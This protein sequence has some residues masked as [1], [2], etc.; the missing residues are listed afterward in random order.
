MYPF[1]C[2]VQRIARR[3]K[4]AFLSDQCKE[5]EENNRM[6]KTRDLFKKIRDNKGT[7]YAKMGSIKDRNG[8]DLTEAEDIKK[9][10]QEY[11]EELYKKDLHNQDNHEY[12][13]TDL[14]PDSL[15][16]EVKWALESITMDKAS[17]GD[18]IPV[19]LFQI[20]KD[21][22]VKVLHSMCQQIWKT[23]QWP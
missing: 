20:L 2:R 4:K 10:W 18:G 5:R 17:G 6:G 14:E 21:Y 8:R 16:C 12:V 11:T 1:E 15:E 3:D 19:E 22:A 9:R 7:F 13:I 23:Q